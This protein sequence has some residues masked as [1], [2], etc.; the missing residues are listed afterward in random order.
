LLRE[1]ADGTA[2]ILLESR[3]LILLASSDVSLETCDLK[4]YLIG[5][6]NRFPHIEPRN[7]LIMMTDFTKIRNKTRQA[8]YV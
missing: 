6:V 4:S 8:I 7:T 3:G 5:G 2:E 1:D